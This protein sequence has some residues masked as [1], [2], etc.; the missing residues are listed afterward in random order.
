MSGDEKREELL[1]RLVLDIKALVLLQGSD[2]EL[3][4]E[5]QGPIVQSPDESIG[6]FVAAMQVEKPPHAA[7][8]VAVAVGEL[9]LASFLVVVGVVTLAPQ[10][11]GIST[12]Q[13]FLQYATSSAATALAQSPFSGYLPFL[14]FAVGVA[15]ML[16]AFFVLRQ[17]ALNLKAADLS[18]KPREA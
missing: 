10:I 12:P 3:K 8:M 6:R 13:G 5:L 9:F 7:R 18:V 1:D 4:A 17:A 11:A 16:S 15:L 2:A 14:E